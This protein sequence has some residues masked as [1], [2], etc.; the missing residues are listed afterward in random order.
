MA[1]TQGGRANKAGNILE[2]NVEAI[3][4]GH[5]YFQVGNY[6]SK[7][8]ILNAALLPKRYGK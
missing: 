2:R 5:N 8:F 3:L 6:V 4:T 1:L 7:E